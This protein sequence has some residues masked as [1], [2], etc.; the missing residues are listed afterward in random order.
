MN[1]SL[2]ACGNFVKHAGVWVAGAMLMVLSGCA[3]LNMP[4]RQ[5]ISLEQIV[6]MSKEGKDAAAI[7]REIRESMTTYDVMASQYAKLSRDGV[8]DEVID[9]MQR[10]QLR[11]AERAG[12]RS[13]Y[14]DLW[15][16][17]RFGWVYGGPW[18]P[19][20]YYLYSNG[21]PFTRYW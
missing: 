7:I 16:S 3:S 6:A 9:F 11:M 8:P 20:A 5:P 17:S 4:E 13:A 21:R 12:R 10:G 19:R 2:R 15:V 14:D 18:T 1:D